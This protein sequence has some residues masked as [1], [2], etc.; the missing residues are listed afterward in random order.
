M[1]TRSTSFILE[2]EVAWVPAGLGVC[3]QVMAYDG[4]IM[5]V[6]VKFEQGAIGTRHSHYHSQASLV[7]GGV[8]EV[9]VGGEKKILSAGDSFYVAPDVEHGVVCLESGILLDTF[10]PMRE[11]FLSKGQS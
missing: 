6:K 2:T 5:L 4:Q 9:E 7:V 3:R 8:F 1:K 10:S 11:D